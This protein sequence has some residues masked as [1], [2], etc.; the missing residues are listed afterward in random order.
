M[1]K[2][3]YLFTLQG[4]L[5]DGESLCGVAL[6]IDREDRHF[7]CGLAFINEDGQLNVLHLATHNLLICE[8]NEGD[9]D[10]YIRPHINKFRQRAFIPLCN[11]IKKRIAEEGTKVTYG[12]RFDDYAEYD[13]SGV[14]HLAEHEIGLTCATYVLTLFHS[15]GIDLIALS[16]WPDRE[17]DHLWHDDIVKTLKKYKT[18]PSV[19]MTREHLENLKEEAKQHPHRYRPEEVAASSALYNGSAASPNDIIAHGAYINKYMNEIFVV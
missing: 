4:S 12:L 6:N 9:F 1:E 5:T 8:N 10:C 3:E 18:H 17:D 2:P 11:L 13:D 16:N 19:Q 14:L 7:H 15:I